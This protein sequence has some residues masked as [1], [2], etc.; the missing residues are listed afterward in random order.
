MNNN[1]TGNKVQPFPAVEKNYGIPSDEDLV[2]P[3]VHCICNRVMTEKS[4]Y[5]LRSAGVNER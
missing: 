2:C 3:I 1:Q 4:R 5:S